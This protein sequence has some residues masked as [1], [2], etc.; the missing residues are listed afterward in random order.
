MADVFLD[1]VD[2]PP[3]LQPLDREFVPDIVQP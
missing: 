2:R 1:L 3:F